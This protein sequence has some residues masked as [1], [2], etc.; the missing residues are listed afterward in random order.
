MIVELFLKSCAAIIATTEIDIFV[1]QGETLSKRE[2]KR[3]WDASRFILKSVLSGF[4]CERFGK[5]S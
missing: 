3:S 5:F 4:S 2:E 1:L